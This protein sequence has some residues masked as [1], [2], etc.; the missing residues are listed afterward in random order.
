MTRPHASSLM[1]NVIGCAALA[2]FLSLTACTLTLQNRGTYYA[3]TQHKAKNADSRIRFLVMHYTE[4]DE[5]V[6][7]AVLTGDE[8]SVHYVVPD[9]PRIENGEPVVFQLVPEDKRAWHAGVSCWQGATE[10]NASSIGIENVNLGS[11]GNGQWQLY[12]PKQIDAL[13][14]LS[15]DIV[16]RYHIP[17]TRVVAQR[18]RAAAK[19]RSGPAVSM[20]HAVRCRRRCMAR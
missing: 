6:S 19:N 16:S 18:H 17:P 5:A 3:D 1:K 8:V 4:I 20:A 15:R 11:I 13:V 2:V 10:L 14:K 7:L 9:D 12:P